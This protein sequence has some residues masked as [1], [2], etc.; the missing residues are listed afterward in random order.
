M[1]QA[2]TAFFFLL[3]LTL[4]AQYSM[5]RYPIIPK[6]Q[7]LLPNSDNFSF[8]SAVTIVTEQKS[9]RKDCAFFREQISTLYNIQLQY[10][11]VA[12]FEP[13]IWISLDS[14]GLPPEGYELYISKQGVNLYGS[15]AGVFYGLQTLLQLIQTDANGALF[16][17]GCSVIDYPRFSWRGMHLDVARHFFP[18]ENVKAYLRWM[19]MYKLN[20]FHWH[21]TDDQGWRIEILQL[22]L[23]TQ[24][25]AWRKQTLIG[26]FSEEPDRYDGEPYGGFYTQAEIREVL[27]FADSLHITVVPEIEMPGHASAMIA[28]YPY[29]GNGFTKTE[30]QGTWGVFPEVLSPKDSTFTTLEMILSEVAKLFPGEYIHIGGDECPKDEWKNSAYCQQLIRDKKLQE[31]HGLQSWF[32]QRIVNFLATKKKKAIGWDEILEGGLAEGAAVMS[33]RGEEGAIAAAKAHHNVVMSPGAYCYFDYYQSQRAEEPLAIGG[34]L[35]I[36]KVYSFDPVPSALAAG[37]KKYIMGVQANVWTEYMADFSQVQ[38]MIFPRITAL[39]E[40]AWSRSDIK[41]FRWFV[42]RVTA[43]MKLYDKMHINYSRAMFEIKPRLFAPADGH[44]IMLGLSTYSALGEIKFARNK[45]EVTWSDSLYTGAIHITGDD[46]IIAAVFDGREK[47]SGDYRQKFSTNT[48]TGKA[49]VLRKEP[50]PAYNTGG[51]VT[52]VDGVTGRTPWTGSQW[53]GWWGDTLDATIDLGKT[54]TIRGITIHMLH[55]PG[56][57]IYHS[58]NISVLVSGDGIHYAAPVFETSLSWPLTSLV[59]AS[60]HLTAR[61]RFVKIIVRNAGVIP[62]GSPG[63]GHPS[64]LFVSEISL[65]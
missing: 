63:A 12:G 22:P 65:E 29:L 60:I 41:D 28:A 44:G 13:C 4:N 26:H 1:K 45:P 49:V 47:L 6:P 16:L 23:L 11:K 59:K 50:S 32:I 62:P 24:I 21:L 30:V 39:A 48:A 10:G 42:P 15:R 57:W 46:E 53:L 61:T 31:E 9:A 55:D 5:Q 3:L 43:H 2:F 37:E 58:E 52:L 54:D 38:Y 36:E 51:A 19:A 33:W 34:F 20:T 14:T 27:A 56:S 35:P 40:V 25:G 64:W 8:T 18:K 7:T 17:P